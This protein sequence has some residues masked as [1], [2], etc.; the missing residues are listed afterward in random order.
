MQLGVVADA[1]A[2]TAAE[3]SIVARFFRFMHHEKLF[4]IGNFCKCTRHSVYG[5]LV[6]LRGIVCVDVQQETR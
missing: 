3:C 2:A 1:A 6:Y 5:R 4:L